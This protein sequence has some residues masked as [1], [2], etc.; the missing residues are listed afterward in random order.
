VIADDHPDR[1]D[2]QR[3]IKDIQTADKLPVKS[4]VFGAELPG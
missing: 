4:A 1:G 3:N 2:H